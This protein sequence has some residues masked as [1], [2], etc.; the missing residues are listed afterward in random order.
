MS[1]QLVSA[2]VTLEIWVAARNRQTIRKTPYFGVQTSRSSK[3]IK[4]GANRE[5]AYDFLLMINSNLG[6][7]SHRYSD[8]AIYWLKIANFFHPS[9]F[10]PPFGVTLFEFT[11]KLYGS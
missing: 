7:I 10:A 3:V 11:E 4:F 1:C 9:H 6:H 2:Q 8:M 5:P